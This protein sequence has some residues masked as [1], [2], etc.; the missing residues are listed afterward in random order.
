MQNSNHKFFLF[1]CQ[2]TIPLLPH[3]LRRQVRTPPLWSKTIY[4][5]KSAMHSFFLSKSQRSAEQIHTIHSHFD[6]DYRIVV[7][8]KCCCWRLVKAWT[9]YRANVRFISVFVWSL[10]EVLRDRIR[11]KFCVLS[12][13]MFVVE[14]VIVGTLGA[15][16]LRLY[17]PRL[18]IGFGNQS[19]E[20]NI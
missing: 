20:T 10:D 19:Q 7:C 15:W 17:H 9:R 16:C 14:K 3:W 5:L 6:C 8:V 2:P 11:E 12:A 13:D 18:S 4:F 1:L